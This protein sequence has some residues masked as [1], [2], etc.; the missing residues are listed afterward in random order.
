MPGS[1]PGDVVASP[2]VP[3]DNPPAVA[4]A[5]SALAKPGDTNKDEDAAPR[6][7]TPMVGYFRQKWTHNY[8]AKELIDYR[9]LANLRARR[10]K[11][12]PEDGALYTRNGQ[13]PPYLP[14][15]SV[16]MRAAEAAI[17]ELLLPN[18]DRPWGL[19]PSPLPELPPEVANPINAKAYKM[20]QM[21]M[22]QATQQ[23]Q[24][25]TMDDYVGLEIALSER[26]NDEKLEA[27]RKEA[28]ER[29]AR[30]EDEIEQSMIVGG[31]YEAARKFTSEFTTYPAAILKGPFSKMTRQ[32]K[33]KGKQPQ[34]TESPACAWDTVSPFDAYPA[35]QAKSAQD[36]CFIE[37]MR[38][39]RSDLYEMIG[40]PGYI[41][42]AIRRI[43]QFNMS[44]NLQSW[45]WSDI[46]RREIEA[47]TTDIW[48][49]DY[50]IDALHCWDAVSGRDLQAQ[51]IDIGDGDPLAYYEVD[52]ILVD[53]EI[54][55]CEINDDPLGRRPYW[56]TSYDPIPGAFWGNSIYDLMEDCQ[57]MG[58]AAVRA[59]NANMGLASGPI[60]GVDV[61]KL[62][63]GEDPKAIAPL[64]TIQL[65]TSR[66][67]TQDATKAIV[68]WQ[69]DSRATEMMSV[70]E[71]FKQEADDLTG[72]PRYAYGG[73]QDLKGAAAT[74][75]GLSMLMGTASKGLQRA[76]ANLDIHVIRPT[77]TL[78]YE[79]QM[80]YGANR[81][82]K[83]DC[84]VSARGSAAVLIKE[85]LQQVRIQFLGMTANPTD[86][87]IIGM[88]GRRA[89]LAEVVKALDMPVDDIVPTEEQLN[90]QMEAMQ[91]QP[92][93]PSGDT[94]LE[95]Q[96]K[97]QEIVSKERQSNTRAAVSLAKEAMV[98]PEAGAREMASLPTPQPQQ[99][100]PAAL[101]PQMQGLAPQ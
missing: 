17:N 67:P 79:W 81:L 42:D 76:V 22:Q 14:L 51:G 95:Q 27:L 36:G 47:Y 31:Y 7:Y 1:Y 37:R 55:R 90:Q 57:A 21:R 77:I 58:N 38:F 28:R 87:Q 12:S 4:F 86:M 93:K 48:K 71:R 30:M 5:G 91:Q 92:P 99:Q 84:T 16:K 13:A 6:S 100:P 3:Q 70:L 68:F 50:L 96:T 94:L 26:M 82:A 88:K 60:M 80:L 44:G 97:Q 85:H 11:Y 10:A 43:L 45:L 69:A 54:I 63:D 65:D 41:E 18:G 9:L 66:S 2:A 64:E 83:G 52:A 19:D 40:V 74:S 25:M 62:A 59:L 34:I 24:P 33:W 78:A 39:T 75:S 56:V 101:Q 72:I 89:V 20:A 73:S 32:L 53:N 15:A 29:A 46:Q 49:P 23:G 98:H 35:P 8:R 61:S